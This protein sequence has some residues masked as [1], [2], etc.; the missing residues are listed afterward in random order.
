MKPSA[1]SLSAG[2]P[3]AVRLERRNLARSSV[4][5][6]AGG[7]AGVPPQTTIKHLLWDR[8]TLL[9]ATVVGVFGAEF[10]DV[11]PV[12]ALDGKRWTEGAEGTAGASPAWG[13]HP[14]AA[15]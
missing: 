6:D 5:E 14:R 8:A 10:L 1:A 3:A 7:A 2:V 9:G 15:H 13:D 4:S 12:E 11:R